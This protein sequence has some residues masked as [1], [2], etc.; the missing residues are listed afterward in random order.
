VSEQGHPDVFPV[1]DIADV[2]VIGARL[3]LPEAACAA[4]WPLLSAPERERADRFR[5]P[6]HRKNYVVARGRL[7]QLLAERL[8]NEPA[9]IGIVATN[10]G[11][12]MLAPA[13]SASGLQF[14]LSHSD[15]LAIYAF[16][17]GR[18]VGIDIEEIREIPDADELAAR[19]FST[20]DVEAYSAIPAPR[21]NLA[22]LACWTRKEAFIK[23]LGEGLSHPLDSFDV[24]VDP[25]EPAQITRIGERAGPDLDW[26]LACFRPTPSHIGA[27]VQAVERNN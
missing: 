1:S 4:L 2:E 20:A 21:R 25:D 13:H 8:G 6:V 26:S 10:H 24:T 18:P 5:F 11:K 12:P 7:R 19:F 22:F 16:A 15:S 3:D 17:R 23:A 9:E 27:L 14:N